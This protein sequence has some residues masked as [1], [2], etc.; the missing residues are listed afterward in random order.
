[1]R[2]CHRPCVAGSTIRRAGRPEFHARSTD[3]AVIERALSKS[4][5]PLTEDKD[6]VQTVCTSAAE[7]SGVI[8]IRYSALT[9]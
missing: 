1:M 6:F 2:F 9:R 4:G 3:S 5:I 7:S 8:F